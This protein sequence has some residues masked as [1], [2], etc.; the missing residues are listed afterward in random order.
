M[1]LDKLPRARR[2]RI[3]LI[4]SPQ[5]EARHCPPCV[6]QHAQ[7]QR[8]GRLDMAFSHCALPCPHPLRYLSITLD[9]DEHDTPLP[10]GEAHCRGAKQPLPPG[11]AFSFAVFGPTK[12]TCSQNLRFLSTPAN[13][14]ANVALT[15]SRPADLRLRRVSSLI[16]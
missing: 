9:E 4:E 11:P 15:A 8:P 1:H 16:A 12:P 5:V 10:H 7:H 6:H 14:S 13:L 2:V 3:Q